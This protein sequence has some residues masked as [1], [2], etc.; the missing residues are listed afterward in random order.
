[1]GGGAPTRG[2][3]LHRE[4]GGESGDGGNDGGND[5]GCGS[6]CCLTGGGN[7]V[8]AGGGNDDDDDDVR[9]ADDADEGCSSVKTGGG[10]RP[11]GI[12]WILGAPGTAPCAIETIAPAMSLSAIVSLEAC[13]TRSRI[14]FFT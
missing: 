1:M 12:R 13:C 14:V 5:G 3:R 6:C 2:R 8:K 10:G 7:D 9:R 4:D 11:P